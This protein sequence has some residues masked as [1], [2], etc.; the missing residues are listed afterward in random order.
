MVKEPTE[1]QH[2]KW[3]AH[4]DIPDVML[5]NWFV[6]VQESHQYLPS[7]YTHI[8]AP[9]NHASLICHTGS[10]YLAGCGGVSSFPSSP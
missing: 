9:T 7:D 4:V 2:R 3:V 5:L 1:V 8:I 10:V 6:G